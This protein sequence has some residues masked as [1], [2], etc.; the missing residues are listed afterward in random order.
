MLFR[1][2]KL[3]EKHNSTLA[4]IEEM[5]RMIEV[6]RVGLAHVIRATS[7]EI[8]SSLLPPLAEGE[9]ERYNLRLEAAYASVAVDVHVVSSGMGER[10]VAMLL[11]SNNS[12]INGRV[13]CE[14]PCISESCRCA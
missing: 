6:A 7:L 8:P 3:L 14:S 4:I 12:H 11:K 9:T 13:V 1:N 5:I 10:K 2:D